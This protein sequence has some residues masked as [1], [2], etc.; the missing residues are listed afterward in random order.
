MDAELVK[1]CALGIME[2][3]FAGDKNKDD[4][5]KCVKQVQLSDTTATLRLGNSCK[6]RFSALFFLQ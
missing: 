5:V 1:V 4:I 6:G 3:L 2:E